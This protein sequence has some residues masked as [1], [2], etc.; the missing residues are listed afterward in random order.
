MPDKPNETRDWDVLEKQVLYH[1]TDDDSPIIWS[2]ADLAREMD[3]FDA[4]SV[5]YTLRRAGLVHQTSDGFVFATPA[6]FRM[7]QII[8]QVD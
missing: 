1:L 8:G 2:I 5:V 4:E 3:Y 7:V 6:A